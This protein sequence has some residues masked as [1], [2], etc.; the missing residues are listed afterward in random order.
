MN[1]TVFAS[2]WLMTWVYTDVETFPEGWHVTNQLNERAS[3]VVINL[4]CQLTWGWNQRPWGHFQAGVAG[5][6]HPSPECIEPS[7]VSP[8]MKRNERKSVL[9]AWLSSFLPGEWLDPAAT[10]LSTLDI[11]LEL[12]HVPTRKE[13]L[14]LSQNLVDLWNHTGTSQAS[15][16]ADWA[17]SVFSVPPVCKSLLLDYSVPTGYKSI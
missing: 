15:S 14:Q 11:R 7:G 4:D 9:L 3:Y 12:L 6:K 5:R 17:T 16:F 13:W 2:T 10:D 1:T 8:D